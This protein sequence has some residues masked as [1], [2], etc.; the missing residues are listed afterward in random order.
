VETQQQI[1]AI[2]QTLAAAGVKQ[3]AMQEPVPPHTPYNKQ[4]SQ[5]AMI[6]RMQNYQPPQRGMSR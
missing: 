3:V 4:A 1:Q 2:G 5:D 6:A